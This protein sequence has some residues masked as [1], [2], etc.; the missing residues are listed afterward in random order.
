M[1]KIFVT[2][3]GAPIVLLDNK[4]IHFPYRKLAGFFFYLC[5]KKSITREEAVS[6][7]WADQDEKSARKNLRD[8]I[9][10]IKKLLG[11]EAITTVGN[12]I[13]SLNSEKVNVDTDHIHAD[14]IVEKFTGEFLHYFFIKDCLEF[15]TWCSGMQNYYKELY[16]SELYK[17]LCL[18]SQQ[19]EMSKINH[20][21]NMLIQN[22]I[23]DERMYREIMRIYSDNGFYN[24]AIKLFYELK[25]LLDDD[26]G[27]LPDQ[28][29]Q[30]LLSD[31]LALK[32][33]QSNNKSPSDEYFFGRNEERLQVHTS[34]NE[35]LAE[36]SASIIVSGEAGVGKTTFLKKIAETIDTDK[37]FY[38]PYVCH[39]AEKD[40]YL[41][42]GHNL[43]KKMIKLYEAQLVEA[44]AIHNDFRIQDYREA[45][46]TLGMTADFAL[47]YDIFIK[48][49]ERR[50]IVLFIDDI[51]WI[52]GGSLKLLSTLLSRFGLKKLFLMGAH[53]EDYQEVLAPFIV[54][55]EKDGVLKRIYLKRFN[56]DEVTQIIDDLMPKHKGDDEL[57]RKIYHDTQGNSLFLLELIKLIEEK[58]YS[59]LL[60][61]K[62]VNIIKSRLIDLADEEQGVLNALSIFPTKASMADLKI[63]HPMIELE[64]FELLEKLMEK[65]IV[66]E[67]AYEGEFYYSF[68]HQWIREFVQSRQSLGKRKAINEKIAR[69]YEEEYKNTGDTNYYAKMSYHFGECGNVYKS[70]RYKI[71]YLNDYYYHYHEI[72]PHAYSR[73]SLLDIEDHDYKYQENSVELEELAHKIEKLPNVT[74]EYVELRMRLYFIMGRYYLYTGKYKEG[75]EKIDESIQLSMQLKDELFIYNNYKQKV[76]YSIQIADIDSFKQ[77]LD[78][79]QRYFAQIP[80]CPQEKASILRLNGLYLIEIKEYQMAESVLN[81]TIELLAVHETDAFKEDNL[82]DLAVCYS[83][84]GRNCLLQKKAQLAYDYFLKSIKL[85][86][87]RRITNAAAIFYAGAAE[88]LY[89]MAQYTDAQI[90]IKKAN[91]YFAHTHAL[92]G[93]A[94]A[95]ICAALIDF[96]IG[97]HDTAKDYLNEAI[98]TSEKLCNPTLSEEIRVLQQNF[99]AYFN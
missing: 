31:V 79:C 4:N 20:Y 18:T 23:Y 67:T 80:Y 59:T 6:I 46:N 88:A 21:T 93:K 15:D 8:V 26:L 98:K 10:K 69:F 5:L 49:S 22:S 2:L 17:H 83:Y 19:K 24:L 42:T 43:L 13:I 30:S 16:L 7:F 3:M 47:V 56:L 72:Y 54:T 52:D 94:K 71:E 61:T 37:A 81:E 55:L 73:P 77:N 32:E 87:Q 33:I 75:L 27:E 78:M 39:Y 62:S 91:D 35:F 90:Y 36:G 82:I 1:N 99:A 70:Y 57:I 86:D 45:V 96:Q 76:F 29:T 28:E 84:L 74:K 66:R 12:T 41:K 38:I 11:D 85:I 53:R 64:L 60:S 95:Q 58:G 68:N 89:E 51:Q 9:Y 50:K 92:W 48:L 65:K 97:H 40:F 44:E 63:F 25:E 14:N 34:L